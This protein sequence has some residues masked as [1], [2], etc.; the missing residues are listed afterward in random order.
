MSVT[1]TEKHIGSKH[2]IASKSKSDF[3]GCINMEECDSLHRIKDALIFYQQKKQNNDIM[4]YYG[5]YKDLVN[6]YHHIILQHTSTGNRN[7]DNENF[8]IIDA[9]IRKSIKC[10]IAQC[11]SYKR[12]HTIRGK[13]TTTGEHKEEDVMKKFMDSIH[14][15]FVHSIDVGFRMQIEDDTKDDNKYDNDEIDIK[16]NEDL[17]KDTQI[18]KINDNFKKRREKLAQ[19][20][21][22]QHEKYNKFTTDISADYLQKEQVEV[23]SK[24]NK[25]NN[26]S[27]SKIKD[28]QLRQE[29]EKITVYSFGYKFYYWNFYVDREWFIPKE[30]SNFKEEMLQHIELSQ[31]INT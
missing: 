7:S 18:Q 3:D 28:E 31:Y 19:I 23:E 21:G 6:D 12:N 14:C 30:Y 9:I 16:L 15:Y 24:E 17:Y 26:D 27:D 4:K 25:E 11:K 22:V 2:I 5:K 29:G 13:Q 10:D 1:T 20:N 8:A